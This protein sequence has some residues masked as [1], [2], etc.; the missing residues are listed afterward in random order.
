MGGEQCWMVSV[1]SGQF[2]SEGTPLEQ[3]VSVAT[4]SVGLAATSS[5]PP[6]ERGLRLGLLVTP[7]GAMELL[8]DGISTATSPE[9]FVPRLLACR[10]GVLCPVAIL[11]PNV[12]QVTLRP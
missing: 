7:S 2:Y 10:S 3:E 1:V 12:S 9:G 8:I 4:G 11:G 6:G 5:K